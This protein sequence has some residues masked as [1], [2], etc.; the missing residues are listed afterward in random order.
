MIST[1][2]NVSPFERP[3]EEG[4]IVRDLGMTSPRGERMSLSQF[5][6]A[7]NLILVLGKDEKAGRFLQMLADSYSAIREEDGL[8]LGI[9]PVASRQAA[10]FLRHQHGWPF[11]LIGDEA[12]HWHRCLGALIYPD[13]P[14]AA[15]LI[16]D[17]YRQIVLARRTQRLQALPTIEEVLQQLRSLTLQ[18]PECGVSEWPA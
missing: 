18:C 1:E 6:G 9:V 10:L 16:T 14:V 17:R 8:V 5:S 7:K 15:A 4:E 12:L 2:S 13:R 11:S 3:P